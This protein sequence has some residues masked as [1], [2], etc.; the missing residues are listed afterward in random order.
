MDKLIMTTEEATEILDRRTNLKKIIRIFK[1][2]LPDNMIAIRVYVEC[3]EKILTRYNEESALTVAEIEMGEKI[4]GGFCTIFQDTCIELSVGGEIASLGSELGTDMLN[5]LCHLKALI[6][7][8]STEGLN[9]LEW[10]YSWLHELDYT[11]IDTEN[12][13]ER[14]ILRAAQKG[15][16]DIV[17]DIMATAHGYD[18]QTANTINVYRDYDIF[19]N[20]IFKEY[21]DRVFSSGLCERIKNTAFNR[22]TMKT[23]MSLFF[24]LAK[25]F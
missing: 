24:S 4:W 2:K 10:F 3:A 8:D 15:I 18:L 11:T 22:T 5:Y 21:D 25:G 23:K 16:V 6:R 7:H 13:K 14:N 19:F 20:H 12:D 9:T 1:D 17:N